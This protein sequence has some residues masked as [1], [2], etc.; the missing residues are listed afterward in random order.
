MI[1]FLFQ[2]IL[3][4]ILGPVSLAAIIAKGCL[5]GR[6][7][8]PPTSGTPAGLPDSSVEEGASRTGKR[9]SPVK[10][11]STPRRDPS[12]VKTPESAVIS[13]FE[14]NARDLVVTPIG[15]PGFNNSEFRKRR[16]GDKSEMSKEEGHL[17]TAGLEVLEVLQQESQKLSEIVE[18]LRLGLEG[19]MISVRADVSSIS[20]GGNEDKVEDGFGK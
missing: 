18:Q 7:G 9:S 14:I 13:G 17:G 11:M 2:I 5:D 8:T 12:V 16:Q 19:S 3:T 1:L 6:R 15:T 20:S 4:V 10:R